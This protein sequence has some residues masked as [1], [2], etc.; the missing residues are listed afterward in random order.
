MRFLVLSCL[1][2]ASMTE[3]LPAANVAP[4]AE[5]AQ[6]ASDAPRLRVMSF[7]IRYGTAKDG[8]DRW[9]LRRDMV[10]RT[11]RKFDPDLLGV[12]EALDFQCDELDKALDGYTFHGVGRDDGK[13]KGEFTGV[14]YKTGRFDRLGAGHF[15]LSETPDQPGSKN[16]DADLTRMASWVKLRD[17]KSPGEPPVL[18]VN[19]HWDHMGKRARFES[20]KVIRRKI[21]EMHP[22]GAVV[23]VGDF[24]AREDD[25]EYAELV[26]A[27]DDEGPRYVDAFRAVHPDRTTEEASFHAF[28]GGVEGSRIDW[29]VHSEN[30]QPLEASIDRT[31]ENGRYPSDHYPVTA[32]LVRKAATSR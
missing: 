5:P 19:T 13:R 31:N 29:I 32:V 24:N 4:P 1:L 14:F 12:Q 6:P 21:G 9:E 7:N 10:L 30:L 20:A 18:F 27:A 11:I 17:R 25:E 2:F 28:K 22:E 8:D 16:W 15:W 23:I 26:R 3:L